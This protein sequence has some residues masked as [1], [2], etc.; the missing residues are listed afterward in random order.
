MQVLCHWAISATVPPCLG[1]S[2]PGVHAFWPKDCGLAIFDDAQSITER[3]M[4]A[5][6]NTMIRSMKYISRNRPESTSKSLLILRLLT[7]NQ[8]QA[9]C[10]SF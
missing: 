4:V 3:N 9:W 5:Q 10:S 2:F 6:S 7:L 8:V 1:R